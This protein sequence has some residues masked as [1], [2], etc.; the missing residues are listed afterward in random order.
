M[1]L[2]AWGVIWMFGGFALVYL[3]HRVTQVEEKMQ[4][5]FRGKS[6]AAESGVTSAQSVRAA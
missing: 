1:L 5:E 3:V 2:V 4:A 6:I